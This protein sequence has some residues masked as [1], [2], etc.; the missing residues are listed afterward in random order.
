[1]FSLNVTFD[2]ITQELDEAKQDLIKSKADISALEDRINKATDSFLQLE[3]IKLK[4]NLILNLSAIR[5]TL[6]SLSSQ[7][8]PAPPQSTNQGYYFK[9]K[10]FYHIYC[11][12]KIVCTFIL[13]D[14]NNNNDFHPFSEANN[15]KAQE[16]MPK[17]QKYVGYV[18]HTTQDGHILCEAVTIY[19]DKCAVTFAHETHENW[20]EGNTITL[21][22]TTLGI[23]L[24]YRI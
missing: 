7:T 12:F 20:L 6:I 14:V 5:N 3:L 11:T 1:M 8:N 23:F 9:L 16:K 2:R 22:K 10:K 4:S 18:Q 15:Q 17:L 13:V 21:E 24:M 19:S